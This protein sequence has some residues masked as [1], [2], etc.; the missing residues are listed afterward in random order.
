[1]PAIGGL[2]GHAPGIRVRGRVRSPLPHER[3]FCL[4]RTEL[5]C[6]RP[7]SGDRDH[8]RAALLRALGA[9]AAWITC[10]FVAPA[11]G[12]RLWAERADGETTQMGGEA[13]AGPAV[14][15]VRLPARADVRVLADGVPIHAAHADAIDLDIQRPSA[16]RIE[17][18][19]E[20][21]LWLLSNPVHLRRA[22]DPLS[23]AP[24][25]PPTPPA[26]PHRPARPP[27][28]R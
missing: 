18:R 13:P 12:A 26:T 21:R 15:R 27:H 25:G 19:I 7:L 8:D 17:A 23:G 6:D 10:P 14:L 9:G 28:S 22:P 16:Y 4:L 20:D 2:D 1:M 5:L 3:T 11:H 24:S